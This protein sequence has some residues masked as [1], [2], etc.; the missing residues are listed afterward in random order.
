VPVSYLPDFHLPEHAPLRETAELLADENLLVYR[1]RDGFAL[2]NKGDWVG[3]ILFGWQGGGGA[4]TPYR[5][6]RMSYG[7]EVYP[8]FYEWSEPVARKE[9]RCC[10][11]DAPS[12]KG[13]KHFVAVGKWGGDFDTHRQHL[14]CCEACMFIRD[15]FEDGACIPFCSLIEWWNECPKGGC[16][17]E[18]K[19]LRS[20]MARIFWREHRSKTR[21]TA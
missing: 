2:T 18:W 5:G 1:L 7:C 6:E 16:A 19:E 10:E 11:C 15:H 4:E 12:L 3:E 8:E 14:L 21:K 9:H 17:E 20:L 13:E